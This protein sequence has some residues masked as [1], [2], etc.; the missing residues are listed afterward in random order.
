MPLNKT[1]PF[2]QDPNAGE[3]V[4]VVVVAFVVKVTAG[5]D[6]NRIWKQFVRNF[7][8]CIQLT[9]VR[10]QCYNWFTI[11]THEQ[12][13]MS[14]TEI[15]TFETSHEVWICSVASCWTVTNSLL[16]K[17]KTY[18]SSQFNINKRCSYCTVL[19]V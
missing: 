4:V 7:F 3:A 11:G 15:V 1:P 12:T 17:S 6:N 16:K 18:L 2:K 5:S 13:C 10:I 14:S 19:Q 9:A 8:R